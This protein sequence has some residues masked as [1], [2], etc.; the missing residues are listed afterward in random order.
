MWHTVA[1]PPFAFRPWGE[2][3]L[4]THLKA[5]HEKHSLGLYSA[6]IWGLEE[7]HRC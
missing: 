5:A 6:G 2:G 1:D 4:G 7:L 3:W